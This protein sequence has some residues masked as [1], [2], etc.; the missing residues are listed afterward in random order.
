M[1][2]VVVANVLVVVVVCL[3][4]YCRDK[5]QCDCRSMKTAGIPPTKE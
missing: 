4:V 5:Q 3:F 1:L 2:L